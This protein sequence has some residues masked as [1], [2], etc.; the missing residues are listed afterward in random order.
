MT[1]TIFAAN[2]V[3]IR[4]RA[5]MINSGIFD[6]ST[7]APTDTK[8][9]AANTSRSGIVITPSYSQHYLIQLLERLPK[10][11]LLPETIQVQSRQ[12][13]NQMPDPE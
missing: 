2:E 6:T 9:N 5:G 10:M 1:I 11:H 7:R 3:T 4:I 13:I 8:N 12:T